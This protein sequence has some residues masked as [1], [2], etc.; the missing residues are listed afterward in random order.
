MPGKPT[1][2]EPLAAHATR[3]ARATSAS[4]R[5]RGSTSE[6]LASPM[7]KSGQSRGQATAATAYARATARRSSGGRCKTW[8]ATGQAGCPVWIKATSRA[9]PGTKVRNDPSCARTGARTKM[10]TP[11]WAPPRGPARAKEAKTRCQERGPPK[12]RACRGP[13][14]SPRR[15]RPYPWPSGWRGWPSWQRHYLQEGTANIGRCKRQS[16]GR[17]SRRTSPVHERDRRG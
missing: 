6:A 3:R 11:T 5:S 8:T 10:P 14:E 13:S 15:Q 2:G 17:P 7:A 9:H 16:G 1:G 4:A 12:L